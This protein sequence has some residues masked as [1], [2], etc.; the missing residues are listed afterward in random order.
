VI[1]L[2]KNFV[3]R[4]RSLKLFYGDPAKVCMV[5]TYNRSIVT[6]R[7]RLTWWCPWW[8]IDYFFKI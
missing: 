2:F 8:K 6:G 4:M 5:Y 3:L 7:W 1:D